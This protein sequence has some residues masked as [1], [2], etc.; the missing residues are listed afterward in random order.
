MRFTT[1]DIVYS[2]LI[3]AMYTGLS[4]AF[5]GMPFFSFLRL[6]EALMVLS[7][8]TFAAVPGLTI[9]CLLTNIIT[10]LGIVDII[11]GTLATF[12]AALITYALA[13]RTRKMPPVLKSLLLP[14]PSIFVNALIVGSYLPFISLDMQADASSPFKL[15]LLSMLSIALG[16]ALVLYLIGLPLYHGLRSSKIFESSSGRGGF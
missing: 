1:K 4:L 14:L 6:P 12:L 8:F 5:A 10:A 11:F 9:G 16:Q 15:V 3:A 7:A 13:A 2:A